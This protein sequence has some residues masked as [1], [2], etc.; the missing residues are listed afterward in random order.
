VPEEFY[1]PVTSAIS[2]W[3]EWFLSNNLTITATEVPLVSEA[4]RFGGTIDTIVRDRHGRLCVGD[5]KS[6]KAV[7]SDYLLQIAA[8]KI[9]WEENREPITGG[10][11]LVRF[12]K[13]HGDMEHRYFP[14]LA[15]AEQMFV[16]LREA[17]DLDKSLTRRAK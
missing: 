10:F 5:W 3:H 12:S 4:Y 17:Y 6:S 7:Y 14:E 9:L 8:Y 15:E 2:A 13:E 16:L 11:H 1:G